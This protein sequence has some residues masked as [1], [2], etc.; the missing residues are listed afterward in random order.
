MQL[1]PS[2]ERAWLLSTADRETAKLFPDL[3]DVARAPTRQAL[4]QALGEA[5]W[6]MRQQKERGRPTELVFSFAGHGDVNDAGEGYVVLADGPFSRTDL[7]T[8]VLEASPADVNHVVIDACSSYFMVNARGNESGRVELSPKLLDV[9]SHQLDAAVRARTGILV[10]TSGAAEVHESGELGAGVFSFLLRSALAG[11]ADGD[12]DGRVEYAEAAAFVAA[13]S[14]NLDD[15]RARLSVHVEAPLQK[16]HSALLDLARSGADRF[17]AVDERGP[18]HLRVLDAHGLPYA[19][20]HDAG[21]GK[22]LVLALVG[23]P[24]FIV[25]RGEQEAVLVPRS[26]GAYALSTL[27]FHDSPRARADVPGPFAGL[28]AGAFSAEFLQGFLS[29]ASSG[30]ALAPPRT[31]VAFAPAWAEVGR[32]RARLP[33]GV[34]GFSTLGGAA[35]LGLSAGGA[36][37]ANQLAFTRLEQ[38]FH[39]TGQLD[40]GIALEVEG[41]RNATN[42]FTV[43]AVALGLAGGALVLWSMQLPEGEVALPW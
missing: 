1:A 27:E 23:N 32:P 24:F 29:T 28:Y 5:F 12:G 37:V 4:A 9:L 16:P 7:T 14:A 39:T 41:W 22:P 35:L 38:D 31:G 2:S 36:A 33:V 10:S 34:I 30:A 3:T 21:R 20:V 43:G 42:A 17:L 15:P 19:E 40:P 8:Q 11:G 13:A 18:V 26:A 25:Q 6:L